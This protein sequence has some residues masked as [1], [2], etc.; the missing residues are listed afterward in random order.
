MTWVSIAVAIVVVVGVHLSSHFLDIRVVS[1]KLVG[2]TFVVLVVEFVPKVVG[3]VI[4]VVPLFVIVVVELVVVV[5]V[6]VALVVVVALALVV[7]L[8][9]VI[10]LVVL[11]AVVEGL[12]VMQ[13]VFRRG[14]VGLEPVQLV[15]VLLFEQRLVGIFELTLGVFG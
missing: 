5:I 12:A 8:V 14:I 13:Q 3:V 7:A 2:E 11:V 9:V 15:T 1:S 10:V 4:Q 6:L